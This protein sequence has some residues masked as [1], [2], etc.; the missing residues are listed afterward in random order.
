MKW[1][2]S[3]H[4]LLGLL[5]SA[6]T[7]RRLQIDMTVC[8]AGRARIQFSLL[9]RDLR[10]SRLNH[11]TSHILPKTSSAITS[12]PQIKAPTEIVGA[13][14]FDISFVMWHGR[15]RIG[16]QYSMPSRPAELENSCETQ[17]PLYKIPPFISSFVSK[18]AN[19]TPSG[20]E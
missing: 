8:R 4:R 15:G 3:P 19:P 17:S 11:A 12:S 2:W 10:I 16:I 5:F 7:Q 1:R 20:Q 9:K 6:I 14:T 13:S 18:C